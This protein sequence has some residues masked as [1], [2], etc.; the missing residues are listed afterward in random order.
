V[1]RFLTLSVSLIALAAPAWGQTL[2]GGAA[3]STV[4]DGANTVTGTLELQLFGATVSNLGNGVAGVTVPTP[5]FNSYPGQFITA[6]AGVVCDYSYATNTGTDNTAAINA[7]L[8]SFDTGGAFHGAWIIVPY[9]QLCLIDSG[10]LVVPNNIAIT[11]SLGNQWPA[12]AIGL[13]QLSGF[14]LNTANGATIQ[15][16]NGY[17]L[18]HLFVGRKGMTQN[19]T[20]GQE[21]AAVAE[22]N[23]W[24]VDQSIGITIPAHTGGGLISDLFIIG[25]NTLVKAYSGDFTIENTQGDG[26][27]GID[28]ANSG[29]Q[30][31]INNVHLA[32][33]HTQGTT[34]TTFV[35][36][37]GQSFTQGPAWRGGIAFNYHDGGGCATSHSYAF[38]W[39]N[40]MVMN[41]SGQ[42]VD[43]S[44]GEYHT[45]FA[46]TYTG[47][48]GLRVMGN[49]TGWFQDDAVNAY[50][51]YNVSVEGASSPIFDI[52]DTGVAQSAAGFHIGGALATPTIITY[53]GTPTTGTTGTVTFTAA[54]QSWSPLTVSYTANATDSAATFAVAME[55][56]IDRNPTLIANQ[57]FATTAAPYPSPVMTI[58]WPPGLA[59]T[60]SGTAAGSACG[61]VTG[62]LICATSTGS[63]LSGTQ[64]HI[65]RASIAGATSEHVGFQFDPNVLLWQIDQPTGIGGA[66]PAQWLVTDASNVN[67][68]RLSN[69]TWSGQQGANL[70]GGGSGPS[71]SATATDAYG[72][73][74]EGS[75]ATGIQ[76]NFVTKFPWVPDFM[77]TSPSG[78]VPSWTVLTD[79]ATPPHATGLLITNAAGSGAQIA[80]RAMIGGN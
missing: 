50:D 33:F 60:I 28:S 10:A 61:A 1:K 74:T 27:N 25:F 78:V 53:G 62:T 9:G 41:Y 4:T 8:A 66:L 55:Q 51:L 77:V 15:V 65:S 47:A 43:H 16:N 22:V 71:I 44:G 80:Y 59:M 38:E 45:S 64:G 34:A 37:A 52:M 13:Y 56:A 70:S 54:G 35:T 72:T 26:W 20:T 14:V 75:V 58:N 73:I 21:A 29:S 6:G 57:V 42:H 31:I 2:T 32:G 46:G 7:Y 30:C 36:V 63:A 79:G 67:N 49:S 40:F 68:I 39:A 48:V 19:L 69:I 11:G 3:V 17:R 5:A 18:D 24:A 23:T 76:L 12:A